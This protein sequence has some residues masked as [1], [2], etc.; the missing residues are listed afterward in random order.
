MKGHPDQVLWAAVL[1]DEGRF[2]ASRMAFL[3]GA[4]DRT[5]VLRAA[6]GSAA[7]RGTAL[8]LLPFYSVEERQQLFDDLVRLCSVG[9]RDV[10]LCREAIGSLPRDWVL[11]RIEDSADAVLASGGEEEYRRLLELYVDLDADLTRRLATRATH[12]DDAGVREAGND[13]LRRLG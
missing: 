5:G 1:A 6:L 8:R 2:F 4:R 11:E 10:V 7:Q 12:H 13:F 9:H 3:S